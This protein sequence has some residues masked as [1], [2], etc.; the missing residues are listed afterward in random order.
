MSSENKTPERQDRIVNGQHAAND[1][2]DHMGAVEG[3][4]PSDVPNQGNPNA[5][6][7]DEQGMPNDPDA[8]AQDVIGANLDET[9]GG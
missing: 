8:I 7:L 5:P 1:G 3:D 2:D 9:E 6:G 4:R